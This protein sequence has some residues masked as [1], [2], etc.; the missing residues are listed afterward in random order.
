MSLKDE[1]LK[2]NLINKK[3]LKKIEHEQRVERS[4]NGYA[5]MQQKQEE[6]IQ[7]IE[8]KQEEQ[9][10]RDQELAE[11]KNKEQKQKE[12]NARIQDTISHGLCEISN[13]NRKFYFIQ[14]NKKIPCLLISDMQGEKLEQ[15]QL[16]IIEFPINEFC[17]V[18][19]T[20]A[21]KLQSFAPEIVRFLN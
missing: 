5:K 14:Q 17:L 10:K 16:A 6:R 18:Q 13:G 19:R 12:Y 9:K 1:L 20:T 8:Q 4:K 3:Q 2:A 11:K 15:G 21:Q 7:Q